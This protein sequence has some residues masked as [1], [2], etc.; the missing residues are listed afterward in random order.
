MREVTS[1]R[2]ALEM[3]LNMLTPMLHSTGMMCQLVQV[4]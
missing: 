3:A 4:M 1:C 2:V